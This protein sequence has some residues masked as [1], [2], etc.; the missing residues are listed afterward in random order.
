MRT[1]IEKYKI[2]KKQC[3][4]L[5]AEREKRREGN[6]KSTVTIQLL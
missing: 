4:T 1:G 3:Y 5:P 2:K 6:K